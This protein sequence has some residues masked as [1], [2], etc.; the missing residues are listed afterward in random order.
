[1]LPLS[2]LVGSLAA[3]VAV[4]ARFQVPV[5]A[6]AIASVILIIVALRRTD[7]LATTVL[8]VAFFLLG[9]VLVTLNGVD[10]SKVDRWDSRESAVNPAYQRIAREVEKIL[11]REDAAQ[12]LAIV[13]GDQRHIDPRAKEDFRR[14]GLLHIFAASGFN[15]TLAAGF[16]MIIAKW[17][18]APR[19]LASA[20]ALLSIVGYFWLVG[21]SPSVSRA[22][23][24]AIFLYGAVYA[25][26]RVDPV[27]STAAAATLMLLT[28]PLNLFDIGWQLSFA[29]LFGLLYIYPWLNQFVP[30]EI[31]TMVAPLTL[32]AGAQ[33]GVTPVL[34]YHFGQVSM[35]AMIANPLV[36]VAVA[37]VTT[38]GLMASLATF[39]FPALA[40]LLMLIA[41]PLLMLIRVIAKFF[42]DWPGAVVQLEPS[43]AAAIGFILLAA[44]ISS[45]MRRSSVRLS[46]AG[47][48]LIVLALPV[49]GIWMSL[50]AGRTKAPVIVDFLDVGQ[51]DSTLIRVGA[52][53]IL[54][55][56]GDDYRLL[57]R[58]LRGR[59]VRRLDL[60]ILSH[61]HADHLG[62]LDELIEDR[63]IGLV[64]EPGFPH[65][66]EAY[67]RFKEAARNKDVLVVRARAGEEYG[68]GRV[69]IKVLWP[70]SRYMR[71]TSA[72]VNNNSLVVKVVYRDFSLL[73]PG[74]LEK[75][76][77]AK[78]VSSGVD[79]RADVLKVSHQGAENGTTVAFLRKVRPKYA[80]ISV[81]AGNPYGHPHRGTLARLQQY[82]PVIAR[83]DRDGDIVVSSDGRRI[84][85]VP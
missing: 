59:G 30:R 85:F 7:F 63:P 71:L 27:A 33:V 69:L 84:G 34:L 70:Q 21:P 1:M 13:F 42:G 22:T 67:R 52:A 39:A 65:P 24:M 48:L 36:T 16:M 8:A 74:D 83:T 5:L 38:L 49:L 77:L 79:I 72:D 41:R 18:R 61:P 40:H 82:V 2:V 47:L 44:V 3:G 10:E 11:P 29:S 50:A 17:L 76:A 9:L 68:V 80:V 60:L 62:A 6:A 25:G 46:L 19:Q 75:P 55:D 58:E 66:T 45:W 37:V 28:G 54:V 14:S 31:E 51:G 78:L 64:L 4:G 15:V 73:L 23:I 20:L 12:Y 56:G 32:T 57:D 81:G 26:R 43:L 35:V 53:V